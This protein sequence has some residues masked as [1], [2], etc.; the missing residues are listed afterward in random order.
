MTTRRLG[1]LYKTHA[2]LGFNRILAREAKLLSVIGGT[3]PSVF[4]RGESHWQVNP[5]RHHHDL[6]CQNTRKRDGSASSTFRSAGN[7]AS[8]TNDL[9]ELPPGRM[10]LGVLRQA[11]GMLNLWTKKPSVHRAKRAEDILERLVKE[12]A[13]NKN[14]KVTATVYNQCMNAWSKSKASDAAFRADAILR[15]MQSRHNED[16]FNAPEPDTISYNTLLHAWSISEDEG[17]MDKAEELIHLMQE[18]YR[19]NPDGAVRPT[20]WSYNLVMLTYANRTGEYGTA[21]AAEDWL[22][23]LS[24][25]NIDNGPSPD[26]HS[27]NIVLLAWTNS[28]DE[29]GPDRALELL[30]LFIKLSNE[31]HD[32]HPDASSFT[33]VINAY[34]KRGE[35]MKAQKVLYLTK[36]VDLPDQTDLTPCLNAVIDSWAKSGAKDA[37]HM[38]E[39]VLSKAQSFASEIPSNVIVK[40]NTITYTA[41]LDAHT[42]SDNRDAL[43][44]AERFLRKMIDTFRSGLWECGPTTKT[45]ICIIDAWAKSDRENKAEKAEYW[46]NVM[47]DLARNESFRCR[48]NSQA[49]SICIDAWS[50]SK[51]PNAALRAARLLHNM[52]QSYYEDGNKYA[53]PNGFSYR[54]IIKRLLSSGQKEDAL[55]ALSLIKSMEEEARRGNRDAQPD[56]GICNSV[57]FRLAQTGDEEAIKGAVNLIHRMDQASREGMSIMRPDTYTFTTVMGALSKLSNLEAANHE[58]KIAAIMMYDLMEER[59]VLENSFLHLNP[60]ALRIVLTTLS[61]LGEER[62]A[63]RACSIFK[64]VAEMGDKKNTVL[65]G[66]CLTMCLETML[67]VETVEHTLKAYDLLKKMIE[68]YRDEVSSHLPLHRGFAAVMDAVCRSGDENSVEYVQEMIKLV[69]GTSFEG[70]FHRGPGALFYSK[71]VDFLSHQGNLHAAEKVLLSWEDKCQL[72][73]DIE[74]PNIIVW[75]KL[76]RAWSRS[77][78]RDKVVHARSLLDQIIECGN[79]GSGGA[80]PDITSFNTVL[81]AASFASFGEDVRQEA[82]RIARGTFEESKKQFHIQ[83]D[84]IT[85]GTMLKAVNR[86]MKPGDSKR[87]LIKNIFEECYANGQ[88]G[89]MVI[90][91][92]RQVLSAGEIEEIRDKVRH[93][94]RDSSVADFRQAAS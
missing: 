91:E 43:E 48:P 23:R 8:R 37:G 35:V 69:N 9:L 68:R 78:S 61:T 67:N 76:L 55:E 93:R 65:D 18:M 41:C 81:N 2:V 32:I 88:V 14:V 1:V 80:T 45:F 85:F 11:K 71:A 34:A 42:K 44:N 52:E 73:Q 36:E 13:A 92:I 22:L 10:D 79:R 26:T 24:E 12:A 82:L 33:T 94:R 4:A 39:A 51:S 90:D 72:H 64:Q 15:R 3:R 47:T 27:F 38:A 75:N 20:T 63:H 40:P 70:Y 87:E 56:T 6:T 16:P 31:G 30:K 54:V 74:R 84:E 60:A 50:H 5:P 49:Y 21:K 89:R 53:R 46:L 29:K 57:I 86:L 77:S 58:A 7:L 28:G 83:P 62:A 17:A 25:L 19:M 66:T 59:G